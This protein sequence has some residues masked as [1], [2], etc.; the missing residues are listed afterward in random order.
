MLASEWSDWRDGWFLWIESVFVAPD[1]RRTG[2]YSALYARVL[3][4]AEA[5]EDVCGV[6]L[7][8]EAGNARAQRVYEALGMRR[9][10]YLFYEVACPGSAATGA[11]ATGAAESRSD[12]QE[13]GPLSSVG[14]M[15]TAP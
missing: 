2:V 7:H 8:V 13:T 3:A 4:E 15:E 12:G 9:A 5:R 1:A 6:R 10:P 11:A 14:G